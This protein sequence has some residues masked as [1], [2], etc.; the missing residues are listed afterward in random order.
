MSITA[1]KFE[2]ATNVA[3]MIVAVLLAVVLVK[4]Y[5]LRGSPPAPSASLSA[6]AKVSLPDADWEGNGRTLL[7]VL[8]K[9]CRFCTA[10][11]PF[12]QRLVSDAAGRGSVR[13]IAVLPEGVEEGRDYLKGLGVS[14][15]DVRQ[16]TPTSL[17]V[18][19]T[20]TLILTDNH[21]VVTKS[22]AGQL[23]AEGEGQVLS[24]LQ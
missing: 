16:A 13:L 21:G 20:P 19:G 6:G 12:Y 10:S 22:W 5:L 3:I 18:R 24:S 11:A 1:K 14:I 2:T 17:G 9:G 4:G 23:D 8:H 7:L 15:T